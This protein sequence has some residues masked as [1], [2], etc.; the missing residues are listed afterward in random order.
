MTELVP[1]FLVL[2]AGLVFSEIFAK[3]HLPLVVALIIAGIFMGPFGFD[4]FTP[5]ETINFLGEIGLVFLMFMAGLETRF[6]SFRQ[7]GKEISLL[8]VLNGFVP[9][10]VGVGIALLFGYGWVA[11]LLLG[12][13]FISSSIAVI[14]PSLQANNLF[15]GRLGRSIVASTVLEDVASLV[16]LSLLLQL[17]INPTANI[18][19]PLFYGILLISVFG[20][21]LI[22]PKIRAFLT[23]QMRKRTDIFEGEVRLVFVILI[24]TVIFFELLGLHAIIAGF[25]AGLMLSESIKSDIVRQKL[26]TLSYGLFIPIFFIVVGANT[27]I[28]VLGDAG[29]A[30]L[31]TVAIIAASIGAKFV[32][33]WIGGKLMR[34]SNRESAIMGA[35]TIP[36]LSTT[37]AV[38]FTGFELGVLDERLVTA[39]IALSIV[40]TFLAPFLIRMLSKPEREMVE[41]IRTE[42]K[43]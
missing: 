31:I 22:I 43:V 11:A 4:F 13:I 34:F 16:L 35:A 7:L 3:L 2:L 32:S 23:W 28:R 17:I 27:N 24:G 30:L 15:Q 39:M 26:H 29:G 25:F 1:F 20:L 9:F 42:E 10:G 5:N 21:R 12:I 38:A 14:I 36:Q 8:S 33:G 40:T 19:L 41:E 37:L 6:S 18:P